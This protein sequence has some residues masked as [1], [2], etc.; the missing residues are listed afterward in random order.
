M[1]AR[2]SRKTRDSRSKKRVELDQSTEEVATR[3][4]GREGGAFLRGREPKRGAA[5][6]GSRANDV[7]GM[8]NAARSRNKE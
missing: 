5:R 7:Y 4:R 6:F 1:E 3:V 8:I 2:K